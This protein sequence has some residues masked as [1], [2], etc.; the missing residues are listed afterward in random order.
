MVSSTLVPQSHQ[1]TYNT[2]TYDVRSLRSD[3]AS[4]MCSDLVE[5]P[6]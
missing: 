4:E 5:L 6:T 2:S 1:C 3:A